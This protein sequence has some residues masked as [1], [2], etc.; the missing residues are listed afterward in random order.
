MSFKI[1]PLFIQIQ[2]EHEAFPEDFLRYLILLYD[3]FGFD[4]RGILQFH[5]KINNYH[6]DMML[7]KPIKKCKVEK[8]QVWKHWHVIS[9]LSTLIL[10][11]QGS[12][13]LMNSGELQ[14]K[15]GRA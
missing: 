6:G 13:K 7:F 1:L 5:S 2:Q 14:I 11:H 15:V 10:L 3:I 12:S 9:H 4:F 8:H